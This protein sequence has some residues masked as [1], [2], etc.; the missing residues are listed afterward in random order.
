MPINFRAWGLIQK[1]K[2][3]DRMLRV[4]LPAM[5][6]NTIFSGKING[7]YDKRSAHQP[8]NTEASLA[9]NLIA[10]DYICCPSIKHKWQ[11]SISSFLHT[12]PKH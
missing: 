6:I 10:N 1:Y 2:Y 4:R 5:K 8:D 9:A 3:K 12:L 11:Y 7:G